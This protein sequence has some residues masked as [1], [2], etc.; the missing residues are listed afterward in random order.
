M[1]WTP[2]SKGPLED[3]RWTAWRNDSSET[4]PAHALVRVTGSTLKGR[5]LVRTGNKPNA[6]SQAGLY[7]NSSIPVE[8]GGYGRITHESPCIVRYSS[9]TPANGEVWGSA[10][11]SWYLTS[12]KRGWL[13]DG[14]AD[15]T[16]TRVP[17]Q[18]VETS[19]TAT[20]GGS[21]PGAV[22]AYYW[23]GNGAATSISTTSDVDL[24][25]ATAGRTAGGIFA[26]ASNELTV[27]GSG[28]FIVIP[29]CRLDHTGSPSAPHY[30]SVRLQKHDG[31]SY[32]DVIDVTIKTAAGL[33]ALDVLSGRPDI[34]QLANG[35][36]LKFVGK[37]GSGGAPTFDATCYLTIF[38]AGPITLP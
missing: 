37:L 24:T 28:D 15:T 21:G 1:I 3:M 29:T 18:R 16:N 23:A 27:S 35:N 10:S 32:A 9:G 13:I 19:I 4:C 5:Q 38:A 34:L 6:D 33:E 12:G 20:G 17:A 14:T 36:K 2:N 8:A 11:A 22:P 31:V 25:F 30:A 7:V 26:L